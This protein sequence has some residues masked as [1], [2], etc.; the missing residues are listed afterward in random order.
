MRGAW[1]LPARVSTS[2]SCT[3][4][5]LDLAT[6]QGGRAGRGMLEPAG[7]FP[8]MQTDKPHTNKPNE[9][10]M[11]HPE[12]D[13]LAARVRDPDCTDPE[14]KGNFVCKACWCEYSRGAIRDKPIPVD[15]STAK[16][17]SDFYTTR[18]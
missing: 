13:K 11:A 17:I 9:V 12:L 6:H 5:A 10:T 3:A 15:E 1:P 14:C 4:S 2:T 16:Q 7:L 8:D 18:H